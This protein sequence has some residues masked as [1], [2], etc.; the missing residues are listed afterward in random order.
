ML[1]RKSFLICA[2]LRCAQAYGVRKGAFFSLPSTYE[3]ARAQRRARAASILRFALGQAV[4]GYFRSSPSGDSFFDSSTLCA[5]IFILLGGPSTYV[6]LKGMHRER[7]K[8]KRNPKTTNHTFAKA[9]C[10]L[11]PQRKHEGKQ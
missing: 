10:R 8:R 11:R 3:A 2:P 9:Q 4:L 7:R 6:A 5:P 1:C